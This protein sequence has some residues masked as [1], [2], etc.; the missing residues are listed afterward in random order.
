MESKQQLQISTNHNVIIN[1]MESKQQLQI[2]TN[3]SF[4]TNCTQTNIVSYSQPLTNNGNINF[5][6]YTKKVDCRSKQKPKPYNEVMFTLKRSNWLPV[7]SHN[8][9]EDGNNNKRK[10]VNN[11]KCEEENNR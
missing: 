4:Y 6:T 11:N 3:S 1:T 7:R 9:C 5:A 8:K 10:K 2:S